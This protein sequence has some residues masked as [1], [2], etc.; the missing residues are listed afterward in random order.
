LAKELAARYY[1]LTGKHLGVTG[2]IGEMEVAE[3][4]GLKLA[5]VRTKGLDAFRGS[6]RIQIKSRARDSRYK[7]PGRLSRITLDA[8]CDTVMLAILDVETMNLLEVWETPYA[9]VVE[10]L[11]REGPKGNKARQRG[12]LAVTK[13]ISIA[14]PTWTS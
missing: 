9:R 12:Q 3:K 2:E 14:R 11:R 4:L 5:P 7:Q 13:F 6:E 10:E 1:R 8:P